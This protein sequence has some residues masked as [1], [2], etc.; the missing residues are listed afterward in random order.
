[1]ISSPV[2][3]LASDGDVTGSMSPALPSRAE[4]D[5]AWSFRTPGQSSGNPFCA[6]PLLYGDEVLLSGWYGFGLHRVRITNDKPT[7]VWNQ[8]D[9]ISAHYATV[10]VHNGHLYG[11]HGH[12]SEGRP[13]LRCVKLASRQ[14]VWEED[15]GSS[16]IIT[17]IGDDL[18]IITDQGELML[19]AADPT[20]CIIK[21]RAQVTRRYTRNFPAIANGLVY[22]KGPRKLVCLDLRVQK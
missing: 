14:V 19:V 5:A 7:L 21:T 13:T 3:N 1:M 2:P 11:Y 12:A 18:L 15:H 20:K 6:S 10:A 8:D 16:G 17:K 22:V 4:E 9:L